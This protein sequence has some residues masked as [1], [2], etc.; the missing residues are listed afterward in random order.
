M[1]K[2]HG[3]VQRAILDRLA[4]TTADPLADFVVPPGYQSWTSLEELSQAIREPGF[5]PHAESIRR[6]L[7]KLRAAGLVETRLLYPARWN[8]LSQTRPGWLEGEPPVLGARAHNR[9][10]SHGP[11]KGE[12]MS[13]WE[14]PSRNWGNR[15]LHARLALSE[16]DAETYAKAEDHWR[17]VGVR[18]WNQRLRDYYATRTPAGSAR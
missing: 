12:P 17:H 16:G 18:V 4:A 5:I 7:S 3:A 15:Q 6:A 13:H 10:A 1:S 11:H 9:R 14:Y 2:G 8:H